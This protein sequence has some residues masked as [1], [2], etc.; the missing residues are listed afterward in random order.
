LKFLKIFVIALLVLTATVGG[1]TWRIVDEIKRFV[2]PSEPGKAGVES[3]DA[4]PVSSINIDPILGTVNVLVVGLDDVD[5]GRRADAIALACLDMDARSIRMISIPRDSRVF[6][7]G[8]NWDKINHSYVYGGITL[9]KETVMNLLNV[10]INYY[11]IIN[12]DSFPRI[13]DLLDG[14]DINVEKKLVYTDYSGKLFIN[15]PKGQQ[16]MKGKTVLEYVRFR[17][18][19]LGDIGR[20][21]RQQQVISILMD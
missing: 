14:I 9:L 18:D 2:P 3:G 10:G 20:V 1:A 17:H 13:V 12:Y 19:A 5:G 15:I 8:R 6:I 11:A 16:H 21:Q 7:P 4:P